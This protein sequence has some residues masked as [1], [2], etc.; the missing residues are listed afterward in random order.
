MK[1]TLVALILLNAFTAILL[2]KKPIVNKHQ[3]KKHVA[4]HKKPCHGKR[5]VHRH[6]RVAH[7][8]HA[9]I[10]HRRVAHKNHN[11]RVNNKR[12]N[13]RRRAFIVG[14][15]RKLGGERAA[16]SWSSKTQEGVNSQAATDAIAYG[17]GKTQSVAGP[18]GAQSQAEGTLGTNTAS[19]YNADNFRN[20]DS[21]GQSSRGGAASAYS[22][23]SNSKQQVAGA[24]YG[25]SKGFGGSGSASGLDGSQAYGA[26]SYGGASGASWGQSATL[27]Q[28]KWAANSN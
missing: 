27:N 25:A 3:A 28:D 20:E 5:V 14:S 18:A 8:R 1:S 17:A 11:K 12:V 6:A 15:T 23:K 19:S 2:V 9:R 22:N 26:G 21:W 10:A 4:I 13:N 24:A 7:R 16:D